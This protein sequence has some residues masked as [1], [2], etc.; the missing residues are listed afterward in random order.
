MLKVAGDLRRP[1][2]KFEN[3]VVVVVITIHLHSERHGWCGW[4]GQVSTFRGGL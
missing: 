1:P 4:G 3:P 2:A